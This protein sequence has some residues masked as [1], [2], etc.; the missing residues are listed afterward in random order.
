[1]AVTLIRYEA[2]DVDNR[3][4]IDA[5]RSLVSAQN[6]LVDLLAAHFIRRLQLLRNLG[7]LFI[8]ADGMWRS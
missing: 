2:G 8:G 6:A 3:D 7:V 5:R 4:L 1:V